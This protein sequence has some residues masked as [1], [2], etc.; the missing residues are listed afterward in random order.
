MEF[1]EVVVIGGSGPSLTQTETDR[2]PKDAS[3]VR[4]NNFF[5]ED[6]YYLGRNVD[7]VYF[8]ADPRALR[9]YVAT[10]H[11]VI[12]RGLY[13]VGASASH[14][15]AASAFAPPPPF[16]FAG[17]GDDEV[18]AVIEAHRG[19]SSVLPSSGVMAMLYAARLGARRL[20][21]SGIDFYES[22][23]KYAFELPPRLRRLL[24]PN[25][26]PSG[27]DHRLHS[28]E[29]DR[30]VVALL[31]ERGVEIELT[32]PPDR[33][34]TL[35]LGLAPTLVA[36]DHLALPVPK[37]EIVDDWVSTSGGW[38]VDTLVRLRLLRRAVQRIRPR[39]RS[40]IES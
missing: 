23:Q 4:V 32:S 19:G 27:Y 16:E 8:S 7:C 5:F 18:R 39:R 26:E 21:L 13:D 22:E 10:L 28:A 12:D 24:E 3:I 30:A 34:S 35:G 1:P 2:I 36:E 37:R 25:L 29:L 38:T 17:V 15:E 33:P 20:L 40:S 14:S 6:R 9:F 11:D 31:R